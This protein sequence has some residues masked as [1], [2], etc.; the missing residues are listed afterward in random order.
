MSAAGRS[1]ISFVAAVCACAC[2]GSRAETAQPTPSSTSSAEAT[3]AATSGVVP[4]VHTEPTATGTPAP[5]PAAAASAA[6][7]PW[8]RNL[9]PLLFRDINTLA[10]VT[11]RL[12]R[13]DGALDDDAVTEVERVLWSSKDDAVPRVSRRL[14]QLVVKAA[15]HLGA[16]EVHVISSHRG[17]ARKG[18]RHRSGEA[19]DFLFPGVPAKQLAE[20]LRGYA[21][22][23]VGLYV[24][25][26]S[27]YVHLDVREQSYHWI[28]G[29]P[30]GRSWKEHGLADPT[31]AERDTAH[32]PAD[33]LPVPPA[34]AALPR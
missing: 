23:G 27:Q 34:P 26:R 22:V 29:S 16:Q 32:T 31:A 30:P 3:S 5:P 24:H 8:A 15:A 6:S 13:E 25:P 18:S 17:K 14:L 1:A 7:L 10:N 28:D 19:I 33:D 20:V 9:A 11:L 12:Y 4:A 2:N 21:K